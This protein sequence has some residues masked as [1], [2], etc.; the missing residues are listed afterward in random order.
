LYD[1]IVLG[2]GGVGSAA[3]HHLARRG[4]RALGIERF[5]PP[6]DRGSSH[7]QT[8]IIRQAYFEHPDY[9]P[10]LRRA[11]EL[12]RDLEE[13]AGR[14]LYF[15]TG[16]LEV[17]PPGGA[18]IPGV[19]E[20][21]RRH[22]LD[23]ETLSSDESQRRFPGFHVPPGCEAV[24][25]RDAGY[26]L[27]EACVRTHVE[28]AVR[29]GADLRTDE[30][31]TRWSIENG[32]VVV[33]TDRGRYTAA[34]LI[35]TPGPWA[36]ELLA[37]LGVP[38]RVVRKHL[39]WFANDDVGLHAD[40]GCPAFFYET[41]QG[42]YYGFPQIDDRGVKAAQHSGGDPVADPL[43]V[44]RALDPV[45]L[46]RVQTFLAEHLPGASSQPT[47]HAVCMYTMTPD[48]H[49]LVGLH[50]RHSEVALV[51]GLSGHGFK[52]TPVL[53]EILAELVLEGNSRQPIGFLSPTRFSEAGSATS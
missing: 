52:F 49:F 47:G 30:V 16:L 33:E 11:Y 36:M 45:E 17:G 6:H 8:R 50:P 32:A 29:L 31:V 53:G 35:L 26:L 51:A 14:K 7:G 24:F 21:A 43:A 23:V 10:L 12:W 39:H 27:V 18:V 46:A 4:A 2:A 41:P 28:A 38:L 13:Q 5:A 19:L 48:E 9:V 37:D 42:Y 20:S 25:E 22:K 1:V 34:Q 3:L 40:R 44:D 15:A